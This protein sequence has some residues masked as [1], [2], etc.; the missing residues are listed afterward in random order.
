MSE[1]RVINQH[2][3]P[4][5]EQ[6]REIID[7]LGALDERLAPVRRDAKRYDALRRQVLSWYEHV[8][9]ETAYRVEGNTFAVEVGPRANERFVV[10]MVKLRKALGT[11]WARV[12]RVAITVVDQY[13]TRDQ[14]RGLIETRQ[15]GPRALSVYRREGAADEKKAA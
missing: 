8:P 15:T 2:Q 6:V 7:E 9:P 10:S 5:P 1:P 14:Q 13:L 4:S 3:P 12:A 11:H